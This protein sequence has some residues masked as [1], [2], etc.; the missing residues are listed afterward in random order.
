MYLLKP[1]S[2]KPSMKSDP[3]HMRP[4]LLRTLVLVAPWWAAWGVGPAPLT[5]YLGPNTHG[6]VSGWQV[7]FDSERSHVVNNYASHLDRVASD[8]NYAMAFSEVPNLMVLMQFAPE[9]MQQLREQ[10]KEGR[11][12]LVNG[13]FLEPTINLSGGEALVQMEVEGYAC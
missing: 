6:T 9:R 5:V 13:F 11:L 3:N 2:D 10:M 8:P 4:W 1:L 12:E 7:D